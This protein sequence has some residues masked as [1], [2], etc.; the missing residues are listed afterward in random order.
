MVLL[1][2]KHL[3]KVGA[4]VSYHARRWYVHVASAFPLAHHYRAVDFAFVKVA[5][6]DF[7]V[8]WGRDPWDPIVMFKL[9]NFFTPEAILA[10]TTLWRFSILQYANVIYDQLLICSNFHIFNP[11]L[12]NP[13]FKIW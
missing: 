4:R 10:Q 12:F 2:I 5:L 6:K 7:Y 11:P 13:F 8:D 9:T 1:L 3:I